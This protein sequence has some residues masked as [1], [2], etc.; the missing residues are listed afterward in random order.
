LV[1]SP[2]TASRDGVGEIVRGYEANGLQGLCAPKN[3]PSE[4]V[5]KLNTEINLMVAD[6]N[7]KGRLAEFGNTVLSGSPAVF[8][9]LMM[10]DTEKWA[11]IIRTA[12]IKPG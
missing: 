1:R 8:G 10:D 11:S 12:N 2:T 7:F 4:I 6:P 5:D 9:K 3:T